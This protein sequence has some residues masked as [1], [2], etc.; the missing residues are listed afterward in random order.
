MGGVPSASIDRVTRRGAPPRVTMA[1]YA[2]ALLAVVAL[3]AC[4][5]TPRIAAQAGTPGPTP[6]SWAGSAPAPAFPTGL[7]WFNVD[8]PLKL[9]DLKGKAVLLD[10]WTLGCINCQQII[11]DLKKL[12]HEFGNALAVIGVHSGKYSTEHD[13]AAIQDAIQKFGIDHPVV[14][15]PD[16]AIW[17]TYNVSAW[18]TLVLIDPAG[19]LVGMHA[20]EG[21]YPLFQP[22][23]SSLI[24]EFTAKGQINR[25]PLPL[26]LQT[27]TT[28]TLLA[29]PGAVL[30][31]P[32]HNRLFIADSGHNRVL[33]SDLAGK[34]EQAIG[35][36]KAGFADGGASEATFRQPQGLALAAN[37]NTLYVADTANHAI[38][39]IDLAT[40]SVTTI[41]GTG[42]QLT[43]LPAPG[44]NARQTA[45]SSPWGLTLIGDTLYI[46]MAGTHQLWAMNLTASTVS[47]F[48]GTSREGIDD[49]ERLHATLAQP[50]GLVSEGGPNGGKLFW[51]DPESSSVRT[52]PVAGD[53]SVQTLVGTG[54]FDYGN[55]DGT[56][57]NARIQHAQGIAIGN[58]SLFIADTYNH[59]IRALNLATER[60]TT[61]AGSG[62]HGWKDGPAKQAE[63]N[64]PSG[65]SYGAGRIYV[66]DTNNNLI[67]VVDAATGQ[68]STL[69]FSNL[70]A[71]MAPAAGHITRVMLPAQQVSPG[72]ANL[73]VQV[74]A[75]KGYHLNS[76]APSQLSLSSSNPAVLELGETA[77]K[78]STDGSSVS[79][80]VPVRV[81]PG[82]A[83]L[84]GEA[85]VYYCRTG[86]EA[87]CFIHRV[88]ITAA[89]TVA[90]GASA[91]QV[92]LTYALPTVAP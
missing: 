19:K 21:V 14:N 68:V 32:A 42:Q 63:F 88:E 24:S 11:P 48:A 64:E 12:E 17:Q 73:E 56:G 27:T 47:V 50:S 75:P 52:V 22:I 92:S 72:A 25:A 34:L 87:L 71:A 44:A 36:G 82:S 74:T 39:S 41:A 20:G 40:G 45:M 16:F 6:T 58:G 49:G 23:I 89:V 31:D 69:T 80:P 51:V 33:V 86:E 76:L 53:G 35:S 91:G 66:A 29:F 26:A 60:V 54:L 37:G 83:T 67:R 4:G 13:N 7:T 81:R 8:H 9:S 79:I 43:A 18:P 5:H 57:K 2:V 59:K 65:L 28:D 70:S 90:A 77:L 30:A 15:D 55:N 62:S 78:W 38:R 61:V 10:F 84:T 46:A 1:L 85:A 3:T